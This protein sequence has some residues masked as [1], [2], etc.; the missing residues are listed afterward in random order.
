MKRTNIFSISVILGALL[1]LGAVKA[2]AQAGAAPSGQWG[3]GVVGSGD[4]GATVQYA[5]SPSVQVGLGL[6]V[7]G[8]SVSG[9]STTNYGTELYARF[10]LEGKV[11]PIIQAGFRRTS[12]DVSSGTTTVSVETNQIYGAVGLEYFVNRN[13]GVYGTV[14]LL[15][16]T[17]DPSVTEYG[18]R[19]PRIGLEWYFDK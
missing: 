15:A 9:S 1:V 3:I 10:I 11:N 5:F 4:I 19:N 14:E 16:L 6:S 2:S 18:I 17:F 8:R 7:D 13:V 12:T